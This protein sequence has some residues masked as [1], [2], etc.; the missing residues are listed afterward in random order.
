MEQEL[1]TLFTHLTQR[2][3]DLESELKT[4]TDTIDSKEIVQQFEKRGNKSKSKTHQ[5]FIGSKSSY[6][7]QHG[8]K[9]SSDSYASVFPHG[10]KQDMLLTSSILNAE[11]NSEK[12]QK[13]VNQSN[14]YFTGRFDAKIDFLFSRRDMLYITPW[15]PAM[16]RNYEL[17]KYIVKNKWGVVYDYFGGGGGDLLSFMLFYP[18]H[19]L[20]HVTDEN[21]DLIS[22][23]IGCFLE[24][25]KGKYPKIADVKLLGY[26]SKNIKSE[27]ECMDMALADMERPGNEPIQHIDLLYLDPPWTLKKNQHEDWFA[28]SKKVQLKEESQPHEILRFVYKKI[29]KPLWKRCTVNMI[30]IKGR[31]DIHVMKKF[32]SYFHDY[33]LVENIAFAPFHHEVNF[34]VLKKTG[35]RVV[36]WEASK[37][38]M[39]VYGDVRKSKFAQNPH[40]NYGTVDFRELVN[41]EKVVQYTNEEKEHME[42]WQK[43]DWDDGRDEEDATEVDPKYAL[44]GHGFNPHTPVNLWKPKKLSPEDREKLFHRGK[45]IPPHRRPKKSSD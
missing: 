32:I 2:I 13:I 23:N 14:E 1:Y 16:V 15:E 31:F 38:Y 11:Y 26:G 41:Y 33:E 42:D 18:T 9:H 37:L 36:V 45:Y 28:K 5:K 35:T 17:N 29:I 7:V 19:I 20:F 3:H 6:V 25:M 21:Y 24:G 27:F 12:M 10:E 30:V 22:H 44:P 39:D 4:Q 8:P 34:Y 43:E 40:D